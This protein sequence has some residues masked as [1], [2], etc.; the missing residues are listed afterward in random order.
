MLVFGQMKKSDLAKD[1]ALRNQ[2]GTADAAD[3]LD[4]AVSQVIRTLRAG[5]AARL[6]G[7]GTI[8]PGKRW[9]FRREQK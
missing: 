5:R 3:Q 6:P 4:S 9:T 7:L 1:I 2:V 8:L